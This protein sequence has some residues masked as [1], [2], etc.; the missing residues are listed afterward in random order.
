MKKIIMLWLFAIISIVGIAQNTT[1]HLS[2][3]G[4]PITGTIT[5]FQ[6]K[7]QAKRCS[8]DKQTSNSLGVGCRAFKG[9]FI[10]NKV[11]IFVYYDENT[12]VVYRVKSVISKI[13]E[14]IADQK[15][16]YIKNMLLQK[17]GMTYSNYGEQTG[18][19]SFSILVEGK[20]LNPKMDLTS[21]PLSSNGFKGNID[22]FIAKDETFLSYPFDYNLH[23]D[24][25]DAINYEKHLNRDLEDI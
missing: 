7:L 9:N 3:M 25:Y 5:Q 14:N 17:Y 19:E 2:Y 16:E 8:L 15:Y 13:S 23:I 18:K 20:L 12:K 6:A 4:I 24:Y 1:E 10:G 11:T 22:L 21:L